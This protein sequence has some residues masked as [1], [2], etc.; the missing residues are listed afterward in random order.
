[1]DLIKKNFL[2][3][4]KKIFKN[5]SYKELNKHL[6]KEKIGQFTKNES[7]AVKTGKYTGRSQN[8]RFIVSSLPSSKLIN[9][10]DINKKIN[11]TSY[12]K[13]LKEINQHLNN[14]KQLYIFDGYCGKSNQKH[15][16][17]FTEYAWQYNF[18]RNMFVRPSDDELKI[19]QNKQPDF[20]IYNCCDLKIT[21]PDSYSLNS[22]AFIILN[23]EQKTGI[24]GGTSYAGEMKKGIFSLMNYF[25]HV[26]MC[27]Y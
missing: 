17:F 16:R 18:V 19:L 10:G 21:D 13:N 8:D 24:I 7:F 5:I 27:N 11:Y 1:M 9:W 14:T 6:G 12:D 20:T 15:V 26:K 2:R 25:L 23:I 4:E 22:E 3:N